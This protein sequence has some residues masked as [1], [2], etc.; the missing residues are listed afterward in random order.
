MCRVLVSY[1]RGSTRIVAL[2]ACRPPPTRVGLPGSY[3]GPVHGRP[4]T[5][6]VGRLGSE[7]ESLLSR[8][9]GVLER[10]RRSEKQVLP[11]PAGWV[12]RHLRA[13]RG[14]RR[15]ASRP[16]RLWCR[17][18]TCSLF[19]ELRFWTAHRESSKSPPVLLCSV[20]LGENPAV[21]R[22]GRIGS[23]LRRMKKGR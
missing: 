2:L 10:V 3:R 4:F 15:P 20:F 5:V 18:T 8:R 17:L 13:R 1:P 19:S 7:W 22:K 12:I 6:T 16:G 21:P 14:L 23:G 11:L 9:T